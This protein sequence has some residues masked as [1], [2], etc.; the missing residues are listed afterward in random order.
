MKWLANPSTALQYCI[1]L[2]IL[3]LLKIISPPPLVSSSRTHNIWRMSIICLQ[4]KKIWITYCKI[5]SQNLETSISVASVWTPH[6]ME[7]S[8]PLQLYQFSLLGEA[9]QTRKLMLLAPQYVCCV[10]VKLVILIYLHYHL[11]VR[12]VLSIHWHPNLLF[13]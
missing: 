10:S 12:Q 6:Q 4:W 13:N 3:Q 1:A 11:C 9:K 2:W 7:W 8:Y 5:S